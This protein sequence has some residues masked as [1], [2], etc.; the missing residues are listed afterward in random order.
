MDLDVK[1]YAGLRCDNSALRCH[2]AREFRLDVS[3]GTT[4]AE[5]V[6]MLGINPSLPLLCIVN[7]RQ[8][9]RE[10][11]LADQ[12]HIALFPPISGG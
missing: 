10:Y 7:E 1:L 11:R 2:G 9:P 5:L 12:D 6:G 3:E 8:E 4:V